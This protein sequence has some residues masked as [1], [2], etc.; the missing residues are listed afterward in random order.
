MCLVIHYGLLFNTRRERER[1][2]GD[3]PDTEERGERREEP[4][5]ARRDVSN[6]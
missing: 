4:P 5:R 1:E 2:S 3:H 6:W